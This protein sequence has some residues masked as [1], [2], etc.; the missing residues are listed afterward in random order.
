MLVCIEQNGGWINMPSRMI[1]II[2]R[3]KLH[4]YPELYRS[5]ETLAKMILLAFMSV[6]EI[7]ALGAEFKTVARRRDGTSRG[8]T[9][10]VYG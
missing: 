4:N 1:E 8:K 10:T 2:D 6:E 5:E 3:L 9:Y 7:N